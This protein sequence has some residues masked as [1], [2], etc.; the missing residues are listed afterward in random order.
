MV[1][2]VS[3]GLISETTKTWLQWNLSWETTAMRDHLSWETRYSW[4]KVIHFNVIE[5]VIKDHL[6]WEST[7]VW[8]TRGGLS[9]QVLLYSVCYFWED[10]R[11]TLK[12]WPQREHGP[13]YVYYGPS[14]MLTRESSERIN[15]LSREDINL[16]NM[17]PEC[18][19]CPSVPPK[20]H[21]PNMDR[22]RSIF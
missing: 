21:P 1:L 14:L 13:L 15:A 16:G 18:I 22:T 9:R 12:W 11:I 2:T 8:P 7:F 5:P 3:G 6:S 17:C 19:R 10:M 20:G 4:Q